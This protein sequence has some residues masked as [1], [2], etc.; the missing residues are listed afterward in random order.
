[1]NKPFSLQVQSIIYNLS[2]VSIEKSIKS[3]INSI[4]IGVE[5]NI[6][7]TSV[8]SYGDCSPESVLSTEHLT[9]LKDLCNQS[10]IDFTYKFF[11]K[12]LGSAAGHNEL[13]KKNSSEFV[14]ILNPDTITAPDLYVEKNKYL[15]KADVG[16]V[17]ARQIPIE[18]P[19]FYDLSTYETCWAS[20]ACATARSSIVEKINGFDS[21]TFFLYCDDVDFSWRVRL[22]G[23]KVIYCPEAVIFH[24]KRLN[25][26]GEADAS[27]AEEYYSA[28]AG[29]LLP[30]KYS[31]E[32][33][34][35]ERVLWMQK[36]GTALQKKAVAEYLHRKDAGTLPIQLD[37]NHVV[38]QFVNGN[39]TLHRF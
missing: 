18:H 1:M 8:I 27:A 39:Y 31:R 35:E 14:T 36:H 4:N 21:E 16:I 17:E 25:H 19:K 29:L 30:Y 22:A 33:L 13:L 11:N 26:K 20:T 24:D 32:D 23:Y 2:F 15:Q 37:A 28:E 34:V 7:L 9:Q 5:N 38:A 10:K 3:L 12:N 6:I